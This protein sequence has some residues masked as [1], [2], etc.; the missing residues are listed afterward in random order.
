MFERILCVS[1]SSDG[2]TVGHIQLADQLIDAVVSWSENSLAQPEPEGVTN[3]GDVADLAERLRYPIRNGGCVLNGVHWGLADGT[4]HYGKTHLPRAHVTDCARAADLLEYLEQ[5]AYAASDFI[6]GTRF[7]EFANEHGGVERLMDDLSRLVAQFEHGPRPVPGVDVP[8]PDGDWGG[9]VELCNAEGVD[10]QIGVPLLQRAREAWARPTIE[11]VP[12]TKAH[13]LLNLLLDDL[14]ALVDNSEGVAGLHPNGDVASWESLREG[15]RFE[16][17]LM[18]MDEAR[19]FLDSTMDKPD[20]IATTTFNADWAS[21]PGDIIEEFLEER[22]W[23]KAQ[24]AVRLDFSPKH[25]NEILKG[26]AAI[27]AE[28]AE[29]LERVLGST[30][31]FWL[32][33]ESNYQ[34]DLVRVQQLERALAGDGD[35]ARTW[36]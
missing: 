14:D 31:D 36:E 32:R 12:D 7:P 2:P 4:T 23:T 6:C 34:Q 16:T 5:V 18:R 28:T 3:E 9:I 20:D 17:W 24:L 33:L 10:P 1:R 11:P 25:V 27:T 35:A 30:A 15:G 19:A 8:G 13:E 29:R 26:R 22:G 21:P